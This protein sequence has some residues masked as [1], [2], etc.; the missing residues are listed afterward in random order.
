MKHLSIKK[1]VGQV[2]RPFTRRVV[3]GLTALALIAV[4][5]NNMP[6]NAAAP[7]LP[8]SWTPI[9]TLTAIP[10]ATQEI[11]F[12]TPT[13]IPQLTPIRLESADLF[14][15]LYYLSK[16]DATTVYLART[17]A[18]AKLSVPQTN[19]PDNLTTFDISR[20]G[21]VAYGTDAGI[22]A[23]AN[24][25]SWKINSTIST[26]DPM[27]PTTM[28][29]SPDNQTLAFSLRATDR[30]FS[31]SSKAE[32][33]GVYLWAVG[34]LPVQIVIDQSNSS[35]TTTYNV[36][37]WSPDGHYILLRYV[38]TI[39][40]Q[41]ET[42]WGWAVADLAKKA[43]LPLIDYPVGQ[44]G[45]FQTATWAPDGQVLLFNKKT[46]SLTDGSTGL[47]LNLTNIRQNIAIRSSNGTNVPN[48]ISTFR[49]LPDGTLLILGSSQ[50]D[51]PLQLY[52]SSYDS[53]ASINVKPLA[54]AF[55]LKWP[56]ILLSTKAGFPVYVMD[57]QYGV[58]AFKSG[59]I[60]AYYPAQLG[61]AA[62]A[63][64]SDTYDPDFWPGWEFAPD[65]VTIQ[66][67]AP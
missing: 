35:G 20:S 32:P 31:L 12:P 63:G 37:G 16:R 23:V 46:D 30:D 51:Q 45:G 4:L 14:A 61:M 67:P 24:R 15:P 52:T 13:P 7:T 54:E 43:V 19:R 9:P 25:N 22:V 29:W 47:L 60:F 66:L 39:V 44:L 48:V 10:I 57:Q 8:P 59:R 2:T 62:S 36:D 58:V 18:L 6:T 3:I 11:S 33:S 27:R 53:S 55:R 65:K 17:D 28:A 40:G 50:R 26:T 42:G 21:L 56:G 64:Q 34:T 38:T 5:A 1:L 49:F 41:T